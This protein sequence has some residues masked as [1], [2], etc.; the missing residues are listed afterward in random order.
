MYLIPYCHD[1]FVSGQPFIFAKPLLFSTR[2]SLTVKTLY[3]TTSL[4]MQEVVEKVVVHLSLPFPRQPGGKQLLLRLHRNN[5]SLRSSSNRWKQLMFQRRCSI[6]SAVWTGCSSLYI[7]TSMLSRPL[8]V[9][10]DRWPKMVSVWDSTYV[11]SCDTI[12]H[13]ILLQ[14]QYLNLWVV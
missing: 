14:R 9:R 10:P 3:S 12:L 8:S 7:A 2:D 5:N 13:Q 11:P 4:C 6:L 1:N